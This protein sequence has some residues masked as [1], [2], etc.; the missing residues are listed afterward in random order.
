MPSAQARPDLLLPSLHQSAEHISHLA[1]G[2]KVLANQGGFWAGAADRAAAPG[3]DSKQQLT[4]TTGAADR[5]MPE[6]RSLPSGSAKR[7]NLRLPELER[8]KAFK[9]PASQLPVLALGT[10]WREHWRRASR[11]RS[12]AKRVVTH[13]GIP[14]DAVEGEER[15]PVIHQATHKAWPPA[16][17][18][19]SAS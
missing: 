12:R 15:I 6:D 9:P 1:I 18:L 3:A 19:W 7:C 17:K 10:R 8:Q 13:P 14:L 16:S 4:A 11:P 5:E 2:L